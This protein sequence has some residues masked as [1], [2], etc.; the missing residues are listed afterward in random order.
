[1]TNEAV[2][3]VLRPFDHM[4]RQRHQQR[5]GV[6]FHRRKGVVDIRGGE[7]RHVVEVRV[8]DLDGLALDRTPHDGRQKP[9]HFETDF[10][11]RFDDPVNLETI[12]TGYGC[13]SQDRTGQ[14]RT[15]QDRGG[16]RERDG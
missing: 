1:M 16:E 10:F 11:R 8:Q 3:V 4:L 13:A 5:A 15:G 2:C 7:Q 6:D 9:A 14:G 12:P